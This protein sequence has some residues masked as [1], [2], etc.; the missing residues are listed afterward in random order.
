MIGIAVPNP[1][2]FKRWIIRVNN[3]DWHIGWDY[4]Q[5]E[6]NRLQGH[7]CQID[8]C[9]VSFEFDGESKK[10]YNV[11]FD[12]PDRPPCYELSTVTRKKEQEPFGWAS[13]EGCG[14]DIFVHENNIVSEGPFVE[15]AEIWHTTSVAYNGRVG[16]DDVKIC[17]P[18]VPKKRSA[19][20]NGG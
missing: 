13:R 3:R 1:D 14:C 8:G 2:V 6:V 19:E 12:L 16:A 9:T 15:G 11:K 10:I 20:N 5:S 17:C 7:F 18:V 4:S